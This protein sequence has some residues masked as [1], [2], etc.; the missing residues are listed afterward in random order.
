MNKVCNF[1]KFPW[2]L[3]VFKPGNILYVL[4]AFHVAVNEIFEHLFWMFIWLLH[5]NMH[6][7][8]PCH[9]NPKCRIMMPL[10]PSPSLWLQYNTLTHRLCSSSLVDYNGLTVVSW[11]GAHS[12]VKLPSFR[13][14]GP[15]SH[16]T[17]PS[18]AVWPVG[19]A[20][21]LEKVSILLCLNLCTCYR[22]VIS[23]WNTGLSCMLLPTITV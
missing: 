4:Q 12:T 7:I 13:I 19:S 5:K 18:P 1:S 2:T 11:R 6:I 15:S 20:M 16:N 23:N 14:P 17:S 21:S 3:P 9:M 10:K 22:T 8:S